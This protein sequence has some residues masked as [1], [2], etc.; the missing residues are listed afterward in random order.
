MLRDNTATLAAPRIKPTLWR[1]YWPV[2]AVA[3]SVAF[4]SII[5]TLITTRSMEERQ[6]VNYQELRRDVESI[7]KSQHRILA[8]I[9]ESAKEEVDRYVSRYT[10]TGFL[11]STDGYLATSYHVI[12]DADSV[13]IANDQFGP[14]KVKIVYSDPSVDISILRK[15]DTTQSQYAVAA[16]YY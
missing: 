7:R 3:A 1:K 16:V 13:Y 10:G 15:I 12:K 9:A 14:L 6:K 8:D 4:V 2:A 11:I 5:G